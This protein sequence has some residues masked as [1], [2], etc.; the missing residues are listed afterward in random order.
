MPK[1]LHLLVCA[2]AV[3]ILQ[4]LQGTPNAQ[5]AAAAAAAAESQ[6]GNGCTNGEADAGMRPRVRR[7]QTVNRPDLIHNTHDIDGAQPHCRNIFRNPRQTDPLS[8]CYK[9]ADR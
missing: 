6:G 1:Q 2:T 8:P 5:P 7:P 4:L 3:S 9:L